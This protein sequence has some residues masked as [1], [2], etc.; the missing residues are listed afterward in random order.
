MSKASSQRV[1]G[2]QANIP[3]S[4][5]ISNGFIV[6]ANVGATVY[7]SVKATTRVWSEAKR[8]LTSFSAGF[9]GIWLTQDR[10]NLMLETLYVFDSRINNDSDIERSI[11]VII[12]PA[13]RHAIDFGELQIVPGVGVL[14]TISESS[15]DAAIFFHLSFEDP[16]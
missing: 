8:T 16:Y 13:F 11:S 9:S 10:N 1:V 6:H 15:L 5:R 7:P 12:N 3:A 2:V 4:K 14:L